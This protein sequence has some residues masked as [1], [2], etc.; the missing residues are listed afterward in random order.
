MA[1]FYFTKEWH[2]MHTDTNEVQAH[3]YVLKVQH[4]KKIVREGIY[5]LFILYLLA[6]KSNRVTRRRGSCLPMSSTSHTPNSDVK[7]QRNVIIIPDAKASSKSTDVK[8]KQSRGVCCFV[9]IV[10]N[11]VH[12]LRYHDKG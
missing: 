4:L 8:R 5:G 9:T 10:S 2:V 12:S 3:T 1:K 11:D 7:Y 6:L